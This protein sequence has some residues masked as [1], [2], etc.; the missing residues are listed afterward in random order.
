MVNIIHL[1]KCYSL[2]PKVFNRRTLK[3]ENI[4]T[5]LQSTATFRNILYSVIFKKAKKYDEILFINCEMFICIWFWF[6]LCCIIISYY[7]INVKKGRIYSPAFTNMWY[8]F[9]ISILCNFNRFDNPAS[10]ALSPARQLTYNYLTSVNFWL[11]LF[12]CDLCCDWTMGTVP[13]V[14]TF[15]DVRNLA[16]LTTY[17]LLL[18]LLWVAFKTDNQQH[19]TA[20]IMV[21]EFYFEYII[22][23]APVV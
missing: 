20:I 9:V 22:P 17:S 15:F 23:K 18:A 1:N 21:R 3:L 2:R 10:V 16:T 4:V 6:W 14:E 8:I 12:P 7:I 13:L 11:L 19:S 5:N